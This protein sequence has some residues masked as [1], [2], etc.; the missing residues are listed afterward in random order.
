MRGA[1][2]VLVHGWGFDSGVWDPLRALM[3]NTVTRVHDLGF[4]GHPAE[5]LP[6]S[7]AITGAPVVAVGHSLGFM[8]L[9]H[10]RPFAWD[11]LV[12]VCGMPRFTAGGLSP[13][14]G[15]AIAGAHG[16]AHETGTSS[17][18]GGLSPTLRRR[19]GSPEKWRGGDG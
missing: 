15:A 2:L 9:L 5:A 7:T 14:R 13:W 3:G 16:S 1:Q 17:H 11:A 10:H 6:E 12:S 4:F 8:W 18:C 19:A